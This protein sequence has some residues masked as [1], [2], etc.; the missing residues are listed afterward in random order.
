MNTCQ[1]QSPKTASQWSFF[2]P[3]A[4]LVAISASPCVLHAQG[5]PTEQQDRIHFLASHHNEIHREVKLT[6][7]GYTAVTES[8]NPAIIKEL[9][10]HVTY[11]S[12]RLG[13]GQPVRRWDPAFAAFFEQYKH[14]KHNIEKTTKGIR[15]EV[16]GDTPEAIAAAQQHA[17]VVS[18]FVTLGIEAVQQKHEAP[19]T[20]KKSLHP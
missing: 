14:L 9:H 10:R 13:G 16:T 6:D 11:M 19:A 20:K 18:Q 5:M 1:A 15:I 2:L 8:D 12:E 17:A 7:T 3:V 4:V